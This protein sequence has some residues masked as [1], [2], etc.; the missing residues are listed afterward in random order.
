[1]IAEIVA[2]GDEVRTGALVDSNSGHIAE[3]LTLIG[4]DVH[5]H[6]AVGDDLETLV[7]LFAE[8]S[9]RADVAVVTGGL[10][11]TQDDLTVEAAAVAAGCGLKLDERALRE[12]EQFFTERGRTMSPS[13][14]KQANLPQGAVVLYN[15]VG[16]APG[17]QLRINR[18]V[19]FCLPGVPYEMKIMLKDQ[20]V[21]ALQALQGDKRCHYLVRT[22]SSF[23]LP[24]STVGEKVMG[25]EAAFPHIKVGL[26]AKFPE[27]QVKLYATADDTRQGEAIL[28][29]AGQWVADRLGANLF[30]MR[31]ESMA[32]TV[33]RLLLERSATLALAESC[34]G[35]L[36]ANWITNSAGSSD[37]FLLSAV[38]YANQA[39]IDILGVCADTLEDVG[40]VHER[41]AAEM[42]EGVRLKAGATYGVGITGIAGPGGATPDKPVGTVCIAVADAHRTVTGRFVF[43]FGKRLMNKKI[44]ATAALDMLRRVMM[45]AKAD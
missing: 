25:L 6:H 38:T 31:G 45:G 21:P 7:A 2:T 34:T 10:G 27:I 44:F 5:R 33:G 35:G 39:K 19:F 29:E 20:V 23:G 12:I 24:E 13:N 41:V 14:K 16:T 4:V 42:A 15:P 11:P 36:A 43:S 32:E 9:R 8:I 17:F 22:L 1:M 37:Y 30:S 3:Q 28:D 26:R 40:A 18:C